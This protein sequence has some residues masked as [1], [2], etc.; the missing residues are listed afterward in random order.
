MLLAGEERGRMKVLELVPEFEEGG[1]ERY[2]LA[3]SRKLADFGHDVVLVTSGGKL[4]RL[5]DPRVSLWKLPVHRKELL[6]G[7]YCALKIAGKVKK[8]GID[9]LHAH[10]RV[11]A[12]I[13]MWV[14]QITRIPF[15]VTAHVLFGNR[16]RWIYLP[17][18]RAFCV[19]CVSHSV[20]DG[21]ASCFEG[22]TRVVLNGLDEPKVHWQGFDSSGPVRFLFVGRL[23][24]VKGLQDALE[25]LSGLGGDWVLDVVGDGPYRSELEE[26][27]RNLGIA[28]RVSF[29]GYRDDPDLWMARCSCLL[30]PSHTEGMSL[31]LCRAIQIQVPI[32]GSDI[33]PV[34][35]FC[36]NP[37][38]LLPPKDPAAWR[39]ALEAFMTSH[40]SPSRFDPARIPTIDE[41]ARVVEAVYR[42]AVA[43]FGKG[44][45]RS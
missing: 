4:E 23:S 12:W 32:L 8:E 34:R 26:Q 40:N 28:D 43:S 9:L 13:A 10:S 29:H 6:T 24:F 31:T 30:F 44:E 18:R 38:S 20:K 41:N 42:E 39:R 27:A 3:L 2:V 22:N 33:P 36:S 1:V 16:S 15:V 45:T 5:L 19:L 25:A 37:E 21:M 11:P 14:S 7:A 35:E 17:Y